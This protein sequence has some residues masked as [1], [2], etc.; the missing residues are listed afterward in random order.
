MATL[1]ERYEEGLI[2]LGYTKDE[3]APTRKYIVYKKEGRQN[4]YLG[5]SGAVRVGR[6]VSATHPLNDRAKH[7]LLTV[8]DKNELLKAINK[9]HQN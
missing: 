7:R 5:K 1:R 8:T 9:K 6:I 3:N 2:T 4:I